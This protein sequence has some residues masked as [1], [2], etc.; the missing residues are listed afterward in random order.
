MSLFLAEHLLC[1][2]DLNVG[3]LG[4]SFIYLFLH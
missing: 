2:G 1:R 3:A 4:F